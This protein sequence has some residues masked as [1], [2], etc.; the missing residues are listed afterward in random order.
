MGEEDCNT[1]AAPHVIKKKKKATKK[2]FLGVQVSDGIRVSATN[3][4]DL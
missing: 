2:E 4:A 3:A 1:K